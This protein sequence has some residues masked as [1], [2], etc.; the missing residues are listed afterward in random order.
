[1]TMQTTFSRPV[2]CTGIG[3]HSGAPATLTLKPAQA[4]RGIAFKRTDVE[5]GR[6]VI[7]ARWDMVADT[8]LGT[9]LK[10]RHNVS[11]STVEHVM[12]AL[13]GA[14][15]DNA[16]IEVDGPEAPIM[17]GSSEPF[18]AL[19]RE[20]GI[21]RLDTPRKVIRVVKEV[22]VQQGGSTAA[23]RPYF[24]C[25][26]DVTIDYPHPLVA[27]QHGVYDFSRLSFAEALSAARTF[28]FAQEIDQMRAHG[29]ARGGSLDNAVVMGEHG[30]LNEGGLRFSDE[31][32]RH[33]TL[34]CV[35]DLYLAGW[36]IE[37]EFSFQRPGHGINNVL[38]RAL[39]NDR[40]AWKLVSTAPA[41]R[42]VA[43]AEQGVAAYF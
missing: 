20:A 19:I 28:C 12:A 40:S 14:G 11:L 15:V 1:M 24:G 39:M 29:L 16:V 4:D 37:G 38:L 9:T 30:V 43:Y 26:L 13:W 35:G 17:D 34:D 27:R 31:M 25:V 41:P 8:R 5:K 42:P 33:K 2:S 23:V 7:P 10:N 21:R 22:S 36:R 6:G 32:L 3:L 18:L